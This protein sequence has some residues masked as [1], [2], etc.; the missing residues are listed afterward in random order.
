MNTR[1]TLVLLIWAVGALLLICLIGGLV[2]SLAS[3]RETE[4]PSVDILSPRDG[5]QVQVGQMVTVH[6]T[7]RDDA[8]G[9]TRVELWADGKLVE[10]GTSSQGAAVLS[11]AQGWQA[12]SPG[13]HAL[14]VRAF[15]DALAQGQATIRLEAV[16]MD[17]GALEEIAEEVS[18]D[19]EVTPGEAP[20]EPEFP[21]EE[22]LP[23]EMASHPPGGFPTDEEPSSSE[24]GA[25]NLFLLPPD[26][27]LVGLQVDTVDRMAGAIIPGFI[28][29][30]LQESMLEFKALSFEVAGDYDKVYCYASL[31]GQPMERLPRE[32]NRFFDAAGGRSWDIAEHAGGE[33]GVFLPLPEDESME[34][35][36]EGYGW[37]GSELHYLGRIQ[38]AHPPTDW[39]GQ[40][41][42]AEATG[43]EGISLDYTI[44]EG[45]PPPPPPDF[46]PPSTLQHVW[47]GSRDY[48]HWGWSGGEGQ[49]DGFK[50][51]RE[52][53][54]VGTVPADERLYPITM[55]PPCSE[56]HDYHVTAYKGPFGSEQEESEPSNVVGFEGPPCGEEDDIGAVRIVDNLCA[57]AGV[58][59]EVDY[60]YGSA[61][62]DEVYL[63]VW[64][65][66]GGTPI[67]AHV[68]VQHGSGTARIELVNY[69]EDTVTGNRLR[70]H[71]MDEEGWYFYSETFDQPFTW[72]APLPD[73]AVTGAGMNFGER[74]FYMDVKNVGCARTEG[75]FLLQI[76]SPEGEEK[77]WSIRRNL[78]PGETFRWELTAARMFHEGTE[79][80]KRQI[81]ADFCGQGFTAI[82][83][84]L[85][86][87]VERNEENNRYEV[88][89]VSLKRVHFHL[90][91]IYND[92]DSDN[93]IG[94]KN[95]GEFTFFF[96]ANGERIVRSWE[97]WGT[98]DH[99]IDV[100]L[101]TPLGWDDDLVITVWAF[102]DDSNIITGTDT[103]NAGRM[104]Y[105]HS[106]DMSQPDSWKHGGSHSGNPSDIY[107]FQVHWEVELE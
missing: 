54:L 28:G 70:V 94:Q 14:T 22:T 43:G 49:I 100:S 12:R 55:V 34:V 11:L 42:H 101:S 35:F 50:V 53:A 69:L 16:E 8:G 10:V 29:A 21:P 89:P 97:D 82:A 77:T 45:P 107:C 91:H 58:A 41:L 93:I 27:D 67:A 103:E 84:P 23:E 39:E 71:L 52:G 86:S 66:T 46:D 68:R 33:G 1:R 76:R 6:S 44:E 24:D 63:G 3:P 56:I 73:L 51:Y 19:E 95:L 105:T 106:A 65:E 4:G 78:R 31:D 75:A 79:E 88:G 48:L 17:E 59:I 5:E 15:N 60:T 37:S 104:V 64:A 20:L 62:G 38:T 85:N 2:V 80:E 92:F 99:P 30:Q 40:V 26:P 9:V 13:Q 83:D 74:S 32:E 102:E 7:S 81:F 72:I 61:H 57:G 25:P 87:I 18:A 90:I 98:G 47:V 36:L 96:D